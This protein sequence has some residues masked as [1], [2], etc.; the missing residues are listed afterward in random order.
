MVS[1]G[2]GIAPF[3]SIIRELIFAATTLKSKTP[4]ILLICAF[5]YSSDLTML[6]LLVPNSGTPSGI[7][8]LEL[9]I[10]AYVTRENE[11]PL[12]KPKILQTIWFKPNSMDAPLSPTLGP[13]GW[14]WLG[15]IISSSFII[16]LLFMGILTRYY[17]FPIDHNT[18]KIFSHTLQAMLN[19]SL[20]CISIVVAASIGFLVN[21]RRKS[22]EAE[23]I[24]NAT[25]E[26]SPDTWL[27]NDRELESLPHQSFTK[28]NYGGRPELKSK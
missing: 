18:S 4:R 9:E 25:P 16:Y 17:I 20:V 6:D 23:Q 27:G 7:S 10:E 2:S 8:N 12:E 21:K 24:Q 28:V 3:I 22:M 19:M 11:P 1:G 14:L 5:K 13:N 26:V 15:A